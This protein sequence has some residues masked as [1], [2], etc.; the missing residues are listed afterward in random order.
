MK[1]FS[2]LF[3]TLMMVFGMTISAGA[4]LIDLG[5]GLI[6]DDDQ[7][8]TWL[9]YAGTGPTNWQDAMDWAAGLDYAGVT[10]WRLP[11]TFDTAWDCLNSGTC[12]D[13]E[14]AKTSELAHLYYAEKITKDN[15]GY[16]ID[17][18]TQEFDYYWSETDYN[19]AQAWHFSF[20]NGEQTLCDK[21]QFETCYAMAVYD[22]KAAP[23]PEP[24]T[25]LLLGSGLVGV[26]A[27]RM[28]RRRATKTNL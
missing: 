6:Y 16:F 13:E 7:G 18:Q 24:S 8:I 20:F 19:A 2:T 10:D 23:V 11:K 27:L 3:I 1:R 5:G 14:M 26:A 15:S 21:T 25:L 4:T 22:G 28:R 17:L 9:Q 12:S